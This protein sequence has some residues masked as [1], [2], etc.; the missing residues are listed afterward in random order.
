MA[1]SISGSGGITYPDGTIANTGGNITLTGAFTLPS[2][3]TAQRPSAANG[4]IRWSTSNNVI[5]IYNGSGWLTLSGDYAI[6]YLIV[7]GGGSGASYI[8]GGG[9][10]GA[11]FANGTNGGTNLGAG[12]GS[13]GAAVPGTVTSGAGGSGVII[14]SI[15]TAICSNN[16]T[17]SPTVTVSGANTILKFTSSGTYTA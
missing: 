4:M 14:L 13:A 9:A 7:A 12:G 11:R 10:G 6:T 2:G 8:G 3:T 15:P 5:E 17:G 1:I 16:Y